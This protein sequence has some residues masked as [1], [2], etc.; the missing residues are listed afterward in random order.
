MKYFILACSILFLGSCNTMKPIYKDIS[1][2]DYNSRST[3][4]GAGYIKNSNALGIT[5]QVAGPIAG[6][7]LGYKS[8]LIVKQNEDSKTA[9]PL[10]NAAIGAA[11]GYSIPFMMNLIGGKNKKTDAL[12]REKWIKNKFPGYLVLDQTSVLEFS[13]IPKGIE[14]KFLVKNIQDVRDFVYLFPKSKFNDDVAEQAIKILPRYNLPELIETIKNPQQIKKSKVKYYNL[15]NSVAQ[16]K[17]ANSRYP[18]ARDGVDGCAIVNSLTPKASQDELIYLAQ[19]FSGNSCLS[20]TYNQI[21]SNLETVRE[22]REITKQFPSLNKQVAGRA[23][24][25]AE[26]ENEYEMVARNFQSVRK[27]AVNEINKL[28]KERAYHEYVQSQT[29]QI[30]NSVAYDVRDEISDRGT[31]G[32]PSMRLL[33]NKSDGNIIDVSVQ[34]DWTA[35]LA[36][37]ATSVLNPF[38]LLDGGIKR[39]LSAKAHIYYDLSRDKKAKVTTYDLNKYATISADWAENR[40]FYTAVGGALTLAAWEA[41]KWVYSNVDLASIDDYS[42][43][44]YDSEN[45][46]Q[47]QTV[48][49]YETTGSDNISNTYIQ[50]NEDG[51]YRLGSQSYIKY[52]IKCPNGYTK[53]IYYNENKSCWMKTSSVSCDYGVDKGKSGLNKAAKTLCNNND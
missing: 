46:Y 33:S 5:F 24:L 10:A 11:V 45:S 29:N 41:T 22:C 38:T 40:E 42:E 8:D 23:L 34:I 39:N 52:K 28:I 26:T 25:L 48:D 32:V 1:N 31:G 9:I 51:I 27:Q 30:I 43:Y 13:I 4:S 37:V 12:D 49:N 14:N 18:E 16:L 36:A 47:N 17:E 44:N 15:S 35:T 53:H 20:K 7:Y 21:I 6:A 19:E 2:P 3:V 50:I